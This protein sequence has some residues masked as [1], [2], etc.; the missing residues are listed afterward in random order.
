MFEQ[1]RD[2]I[3]QQ[4]SIDFDDDDLCI[5]VKQ[6]S[7]TVELITTLTLNTDLNQQEVINYIISII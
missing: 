4:A 1:I 5:M 7:N 2:K 6:T 3:A